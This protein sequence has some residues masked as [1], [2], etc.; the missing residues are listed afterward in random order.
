MQDDFRN[1]AA[2]GENADDMPEL[3]DRHHPK[4]AERQQRTDQQDL[5]ESFHKHH[6]ILSRL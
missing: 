1:D 5:M 3:M 2:C 4:P 6:P